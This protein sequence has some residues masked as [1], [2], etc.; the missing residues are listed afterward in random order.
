MHLI[1]IFCFVFLSFTVP[2][3]NALRRPVKRHCFYSITLSCR[4]CLPL[5]TSKL[6]ITIVIDLT[7]DCSSMENYTRGLIQITLERVHML[8][9]VND[10]LYSGERVVLHS[11]VPLYVG[12]C[13]ARR[14][15]PVSGEGPSTSV[16]RTKCDGHSKKT[17]KWC[18]LSRRRLML[19]AKS[20]CVKS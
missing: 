15:F 5:C 1:K 11:F 12:R 3:I 20:N 19:P 8:M 7:I 17:G 13:S 18:R 6:L 9:W 10:Y 16:L 2:S 14:I 4:I